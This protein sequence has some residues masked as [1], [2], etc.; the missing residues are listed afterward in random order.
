MVEYRRA[1]IISIL[2]K[3]HLKVRRGLNQMCVDHYQP[4]QDPVGHRVMHQSAIKHITGEAIYVDDMPCI[5]QELFLAAITSI[6][7]HSKIISID[8]SEALALP[9]VANVITAEDVPGDNNYQGEVFYAQNEVIFVDQIVGTVAADTYAHAREA[10]KKVKI[11]YEDIEQRII[12]GEVRSMWKDRNI[13]TCKHSILALPKE[14]DKEIVLYLG[15]QYPTHMQVT[16]GETGFTS[17]SCVISCKSLGIYI[18][19]C[20]LWKMTKVTPEIPFGRG[21]GCPIRFIL[22][23]GDDMLITAGCHRLLR[24]YK[25]VEFIVLKSENAYHIPNFQC[26]VEAYVTAV[27]SQCN[28]PPEEVR[29][30]N[31]YKRI[32]KT[33]FKQTFNPE[34]L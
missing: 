29:E 28:L 26:W 15:T 19:F 7:A 24:K 30:I 17:N 3:F 27:A 25:V 5:D 13:F 31:M 6:R 32:S 23:C 4:P 9:G 10:A 34:P 20:K 12:T 11:A 8:I 2:F 16:A 22:E 1:L 14:E 18:L 33:A 21:T